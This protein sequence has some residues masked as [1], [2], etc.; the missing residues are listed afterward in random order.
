M[1][2]SQLVM[3]I[4]SGC[5][6]SLPAFCTNPFDDN[7]PGRRLPGRTSMQLTL[8][9]WNLREQAIKNVLE[10]DAFKHIAHFA[11]HNDAAFVIEPRMNGHRS[12]KDLMATIRQAAQDQYGANLESEVFD[13]GKEGN[14]GDLL[15][16]FVRSNRPPAANVLYE[17]HL[18]KL[19]ALN[20]GI[21]GPI[22]ASLGIWDR[23]ESKVH[24]VKFGVC[25]G[26]ASGVGDPS[27]F[28]AVLQKYHV[29][30]AG[31]RRHNYSQYVVMGVD[32]DSNGQSVTRISV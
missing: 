9:H 10:T 26:D 5:T 23:S 6:G 25:C 15:F 7:R 4:D 13:S 21:A 28:E 12:P 19:S 31:D 8:A 32:T 2:F 30:L 16:C 22:I 17:V 24:E 20:G 27:S 3:Q 11:A 18:Q 29:I 1:T 14:G